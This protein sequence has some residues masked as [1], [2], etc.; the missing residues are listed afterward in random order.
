MSHWCREVLGGEVRAGAG[1]DPVLVGGLAGRD[2]RR[3]LLTPSRTAPG[4][5]FEAALMRT[6]SGISSRVVPVTAVDADRGFLLTPGPGPRHARVRRRPGRAVVRRRARGVAA[7]ARGGGPRR[8]PRAGRRAHGSGR[9]RRR[10]T[11]SPASSSTP[12]CPTVT[13]DAWTTRPPPVSGPRC[14]TSSAGPSRR[15]RPGCRVTHQPQRPALEQRLRPAGRRAL[16]RLR[17]RHADRA[18]GGAD[19]RD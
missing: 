19:R 10:R 14:R 16:L 3:H 18:A 11:S 13:R 17:R 2:R 7:P 15:W 6:L 1:E 12:R 9:P 8:R 4:Q 5:L